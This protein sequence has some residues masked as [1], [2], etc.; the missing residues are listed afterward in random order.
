MQEIVCPQNHLFFRTAEGQVGIVSLTISAVAGG[1]GYVEAQQETK[2][3]FPPG[4]CLIV[5]V[6]KE[7][8]AYHKAVSRDKS[9]GSSSHHGTG[10]IQD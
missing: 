10:P 7:T 4:R 6:D 9:V 5:S 8:S 1:L 2:I 3:N